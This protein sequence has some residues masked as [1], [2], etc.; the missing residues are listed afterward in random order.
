MLQKNEFVG[1]LSRYRIADLQNSD[2][3][4][5]FDALDINH[6]GEL[7]LDEFAMFLEGAKK[8]RENRLRQMDPE[9]LRQLE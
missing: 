2:Y 3:G 9:T 7:S 4:I 1:G 8:S 6:D 5:I